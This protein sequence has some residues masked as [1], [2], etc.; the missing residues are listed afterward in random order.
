MSQRTRSKSNRC[1]SI[2][3]SNAYILAFR[4]IELMHKNPAYPNL[5]NDGKYYP[6]SAES[7]FTLLHLAKAVN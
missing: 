5:R 1:C 6:S 4:V 3:E 7:A 2:I